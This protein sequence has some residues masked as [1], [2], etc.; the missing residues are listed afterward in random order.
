MNLTGNISGFQTSQ[1]KKKKSSITSKK[2]RGKSISSASQTSTSISQPQLSQTQ[3]QSQRRTYR[4]GPVCG[5]QNCPSTLYFSMNGHRTCQY[6]HVMTNDFEFED[7][8]VPA[9]ATGG[10]AATAGTIRR[11]KLGMDSRGNFTS[12]EAVKRGYARVM[13]QRKREREVIYGEEGKELYC[14]ICQSILEWQ[15]YKIKKILEMNEVEEKLYENLVFEIWS[16][17]LESMMGSDR[18]SEEAK[19]NLLK[20]DLMSLLSI[21]YLALVVLMKY[22]IFT[23][24]FIKMIETFELPH[25]NCLKLFPLDNKLKKLPNYFIKRISG[26]Q[27]FPDNNTLAFY[28]R[29][30]YISYTVNFK[31]NFALGSQLMFNIEFPWKEFIKKTLL[32]INLN[33]DPRLV[34]LITEFVENSPYL[35]KKVKHIPEMKLIDHNTLTGFHELI[36]LASIC[37]V[38]KSVIYLEHKTMSGN[39]VKINFDDGSKIIS[40]QRVTQWLLWYDNI[41]PNILATKMISN[42]YWDIKDAKS[43]NDD[44]LDKYLD[45]VE[46]KVMPNYSIEGVSNKTNKMKKKNSKIVP[47][48]DMIPLQDTHIKDLDCESSIHDICL[49]NSDHLK[50]DE[51]TSVMTTNENNDCKKQYLLSMYENVKELIAFKF[52]FQNNI[53]ISGGRFISPLD[54]TIGILR[55][56][57]D[58]YQ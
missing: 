38:L 46:K 54:K 37:I 13:A 47:I 49:N 36:L 30:T 43:L 51:I 42:D 2:K 39:D 18:N 31:K 28:R 24:D 44:Y 19:L 57:K 45:F 55:S 40:K 5:V 26:K 34:N 6:G 52:R 48:L 50:Y 25:L 21:H 41:K 23:D 27:I 53:A 56:R 32:N 22:D 4:R 8:A 20:L 7:D 14:N 9:S 17:Y 29:L 35:H 58:I 11:L 12:N 33:Q 15:T 10:T 1:R 16:K 3:S